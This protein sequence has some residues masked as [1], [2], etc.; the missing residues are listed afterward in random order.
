MCV[1]TL[2]FVV[3]YLCLI[4]VELALGTGYR[5]PPPEIRD[6]VDAPPV[7]AL[8]FSPHRDK[9]LFL[10]RRAL[11]PLADLARPEEKLAGVRI[12]GYCNTRSRMSFYTGL[13]IHQLLPDGTLSPEKEITGI[14]DGGKINFVTW[15]NDGKHLAFSI[16]VDENGNSSKP[17]VWVADVETGVARPLF[18]SQDIYLNAIF[19]SFVWIDNSTL[20]VSTI[21]SSR[22][23]PPKKPLVPS[24]PKTLSNENKN[25]VQVRTFQ[26]LLKD[27]YD[28]DLFDYYATSQLVLASLDG[29]VKEVGIP[30]VYTSLDPSTDHKYLLVSSLH[31]PYSF[32]VP[33]GRFPKKVEV[34]TADGRFVRQLCDLPLAEDIPIASNSVRKGMRSINWR[35]DKPSTLYW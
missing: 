23:D 31:R 34:W 21:P 14:P 11:P 18:K 7:P 17:V 35:A 33:C 28:A 25:V 27:E 2:I 26:D 24:G 29:T 20:L 1:L 10:K 19:E 9:I 32:I 6:I 8:S 4:Y 15:S 30:A 22:G 12:D 5:L 3:V 13:G 16:R